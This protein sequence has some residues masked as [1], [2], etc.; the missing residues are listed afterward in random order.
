MIEAATM[1]LV[2]ERVGLAARVLLGIC[3]MDPV[4]VARKLESFGNSS[5]IDT[6]TGMV[7]AIVP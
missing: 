1:R 4:T 3:K 7:A 2:D 6:F 5:G